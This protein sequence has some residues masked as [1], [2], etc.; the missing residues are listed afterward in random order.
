MKNKALIFYLSTA[1]LFCQE[2][3]E[4]FFVNHISDH[5]FDLGVNWENNTTFGPI[6]Y[7]SLDRNSYEMLIGD[8]LKNDK[9]ILLFGTQ[10]S[11]NALELYSFFKA[12]KNNFYVYSYPRIVNN[13]SEVER[14]TG[15]P[16]NIR[17]AGFN[18]G[19]TDLSGIGFENDH[20]LFQIGRGRESW[21]AN[22]DINLALTSN[23]ASYDYFKIGFDNKPIRFRYFHGYLE[24]KDNYNRYITGR[25]IE[26]SNDESLVIGLSEKV[27]YS[28]V[29]RPIDFAY[30]NP[31]ATHLEIELN[32]RQNEKGT[33]SGNAVWQT[34]I[35]YLST[36]NIRVSA[37]FL[38]DEF[39]FDKIQLDTGKV[40]GLAYSLRLSYRPEIKHN[41][42]VFYL[43]YINVGTH[44]FR[45]EIGFNNFVQ[46]NIPLGWKYG[47]DG[48]EMKIGMNYIAK[49]RIINLNIG[50]LL[51]GSASIIDNEYKKYDNYKDGPFP[52]G[53]VKET[54]FI[55]SNFE[56]WISNRLSLK[57]ALTYLKTNEN[58]LIN[59]SNIG[60][61]F[62]FSP[63]QLIKDK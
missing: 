38:I 11:N 29:N 40:H 63:K 52:S 9:M 54:L 12:E 17:R 20:F 42:L 39:V 31:I 30:F 4:E 37:N 62:F 14:F 44:T 49:D 59:E 41:H 46:R 6:R 36:K 23:S 56:W 15:L 22:D 5:F 26:F 51:I 60:I 58:K 8:K 1:I 35:D 24:N 61:H 21:G 45:H 34:S 28:G 25:G 53:D 13:P 19:E 27:I 7:Q 43:S 47:S 57:A 16:R 18:S 3:P 48:D 33:S 50:R 2:I 10:G 55:E 32:D